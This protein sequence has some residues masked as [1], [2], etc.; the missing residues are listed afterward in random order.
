MIRDESVLCTR[1]TYAHQYCECR[2]WGVVQY[3]DVGL[4]AQGERERVCYLVASY[5]TSIPE[6]A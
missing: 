5:P 2:A 6:R 1:S 4:V 3:L